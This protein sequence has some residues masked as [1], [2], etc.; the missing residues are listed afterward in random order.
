MFL[1]FSNFLF[2]LVCICVGE[3]THMHVG[4]DDNF[5]LIFFYHVRS[6]NQTQVVRFGVYQLT[7]LA[8]SLFYFLSSFLF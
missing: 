7:H 6:G 2:V 1:I 5:Q 4:S 8:G 3:G